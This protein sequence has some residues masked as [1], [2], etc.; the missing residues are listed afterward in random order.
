VQSPS[1]DD[2]IHTIDRVAA[3]RPHDGFGAR[4]NFSEP[5]S[6]PGPMAWDGTLQA[7]RVRRIPPPKVALQLSP[8]L[9][10]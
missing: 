1:R 8:N 9:V 2:Y 6:P 5:S 10:Q 7:Q 3:L 4:A